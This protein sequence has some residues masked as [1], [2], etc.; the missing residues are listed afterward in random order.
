MFRL[1][2]LMIDSVMVSL[3]CVVLAG[4][5]GGEALGPTV[6]VT[7]QVTL[8]GQPFSDAVIW[9]NSPKTGAGYNA[10]LD[11]EGRYTVQIQDTAVGESYNVFFSGAAPEEG[12]VD[13]AGTPQGPQPPPIPGRYHDGSTS[14]LTAQLTGETTQSFDFALDSK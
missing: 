6:T 8:D 14:G 2:P 7:G 9:L 3:F 10:E 12:A 5:G 1:H 4:C 13:G 11:D